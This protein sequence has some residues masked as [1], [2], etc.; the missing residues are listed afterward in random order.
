M[1]NKLIITLKN[2]RTLRYEFDF[3]SLWISLKDLPS[4]NLLCEGTWNKNVEI[5]ISATDIK[6]SKVNKL[7]S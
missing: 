3:I 5:Q 4:D 7:L 1:I 2:H 6:F